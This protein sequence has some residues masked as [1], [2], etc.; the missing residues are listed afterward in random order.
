[1]SVSSILPDYLRP[2]LLPSP[3][4]TT[5]VVSN[6]DAMDHDKT[7]TPDLVCK[8]VLGSDLIKDDSSGSSAFCLTA[9]SDGG[10]SPRGT[11]SPDNPAGGSRSSSPLSAVD[12]FTEFNTNVLKA[13]FEQAEQQQQQSGDQQ[14]GLVLVS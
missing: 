6:D 8:E 11:P 5:T 7:I 3:D 12:I 1:M 14:Q 9:G 2:S 4:S 10:S 13:V